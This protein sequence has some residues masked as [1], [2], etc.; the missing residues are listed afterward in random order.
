M[1]DK[2]LHSSA[3]Q[4]HM[5]QMKSKSTD[6]PK[7]P[8]KTE[9]ETEE[10]GSDEEEEME[11]IDHG[12]GTYQDPDC[13]VDEDEREEQRLNRALYPRGTRGK[14]TITKAN[15]DTELKTAKEMNDD[16]NSWSLSL[17][18]KLET[19]KREKRTVRRSTQ[20]DSTA[21]SQSSQHLAKRTVLMQAA[22]NDFA[23]KHSTLPSAVVEEIA[24]EE[25]EGQKE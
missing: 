16:M 5:D 12:H 6:K 4:D 23:A 21:P 10:E 7:D 18:S 24:E 9:E 15:G 8:N 14:A 3:D 11:W 1:A 20:L 19:A 17:I 13:K 22:L 25:E 2:I